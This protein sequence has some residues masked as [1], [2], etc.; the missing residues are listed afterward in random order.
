MITLSQALES[1]YIAAQSPNIV[2]FDGVDGNFDI[3]LTLK[4]KTDKTYQ[5]SYPSFDGNVQIDLLDFTKQIYGYLKNYID[6]FDY[7]ADKL[8]TE[9][10][11]YHFMLLDLIAGE[12]GQVENCECENI[13]I[14][15]GNEFHLSKNPINADPAMSET[16]EINDVITDGYWDDTT[17]LQSAMYKGGGV[18]DIGSWIFVD[19]I[20][21]IVPIVFT[22]DPAPP[23]QNI[24]IANIKVINSALQINENLTMDNYL[25]SRLGVNTK[26]PIWEGYPHSTSVLTAAGINRVLDYDGVGVPDM[27]YV[28][29]FV[30]GC[31]G[32]Y[33]KWL[34]KQGGYSYWLF[35]QVF[36]QTKKTKT[37]GNITNHWTNRTNAMTN[38]NNL[39]KKSNYELKINTN[40]L[41]EQLKELSSI[42][43]APEVY[44]YTDK[45][46]LDVEYSGWLKVNVKNGSFKTLSKNT[47]A[48]LKLT[49][50]LPSVYVQ[51][52]I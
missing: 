14:V 19:S 16:L 10:D 12:G 17:Y 21:E 44:L 41:Y 24:V 13:V 30:I 15:N 46:D 38:V 8:Y 42:E 23:S 32:V 40:A 47:S 9:T 6:P 28:S 26:M 4:G 50:E 1:D 45:I 11:E 33:L 51:T 25:N 18:N 29:E 22:P 2:I 27:T 43:D 31:A 5:V 3:S 34:N 48:N 7:V 36:T 37:L 35:T 20:E 39:G 52:L 49:I